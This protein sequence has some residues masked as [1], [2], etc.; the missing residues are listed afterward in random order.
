METVN[1]QCGHC[2]QLL[3]VSKQHLGQQ[4]RCPHCQQVVVAPPQEAA[5]PPSAP[6]PPPQDPFSAAFSFAPPK[7]EEHDSIFSAPAESDDL[8]GPAM[9]GK[10]EMPP[11]FR[12][13]A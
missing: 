7:P 9:S 12:P 5:V 1:F 3:A 13:A 6:V 8:F 11:D 2:R 10:V 4:V